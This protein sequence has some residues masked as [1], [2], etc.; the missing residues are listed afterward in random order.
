MDLKEVEALNT[1]CG[2]EDQIIPDS[3]GECDEADEPD[4]QPRRLD[5]SRFAFS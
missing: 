1:S 4:V 5:L 3:D 2:S